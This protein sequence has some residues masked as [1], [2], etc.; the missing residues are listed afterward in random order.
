MLSKPTCD[1]SVTA[2]RTCRGNG[3][4]PCAVENGKRLVGSSYQLLGS[5]LA[6][7]TCLDASDVLHLV[8]ADRIHCPET[9]IRRCVFD[10]GDEERDLQFLNRFSVF[11]GQ[12]AID[13]EAPFPAPSV[14]PE[15]LVETVSCCACPRINL[16]PTRYALVSPSQP[17]IGVQDGRPRLT[18]RR[19]SASH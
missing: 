15:F 11:G 8:E 13:V 12:L 6:I 17:R 18:K 16:E 2:S 19:S 9:Y 14:S 4:L 1:Y 10:V 3:N 7:W 5:C